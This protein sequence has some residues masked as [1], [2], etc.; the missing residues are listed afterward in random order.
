MNF[1]SLVLASLL[2][3][4]AGQCLLQAQTERAR[5]S[6]TVKDSTN[7]IVP[8][9]RVSAK[10]SETGILTQTTSNDS[11]AYMLPFLTPGRYELTV[12]K[13]GFQPFNRAG[14]RLDVSDVA[15]IDVTLTVGA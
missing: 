4:C 3:C 2:A 7:A 14:L 5:L 9:A 6:G 10:N 13:D 8:G 12:E 11:G 15:R 1:R